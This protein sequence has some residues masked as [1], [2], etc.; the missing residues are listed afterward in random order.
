M[1]GSRLG[2]IQRSDEV[3]G[4]RVLVEKLPQGIAVHKNGILVYVNPAFARI[5]GCTPAEVTGRHWGDF[6]HPGDLAQAT[7]NAEQAVRFAGEGPM[8]P[9]ERRLLDKQGNVVAV[10]LVAVPLVFSHGPSLLI[11]VHDLTDRK[12]LEAQLRQADHMAAVGRLAAGVA[13]EINNPLA[14]VLANL[15]YA[16]ERLHAEG[17]DPAKRPDPSIQEAVT[18]AHQGVER[19]RQVVSDL[20][21]FTR[22]DEGELDL[23]DL[24]TVVESTIKMAYAEIRHSARLAR[25]YAPAP[26]VKAN[27]TKLAQVFLNLLVNAAQAIPEGRVAENAIMVG[28]GTDP[29]GHAVVEVRDTGVG[30]PDALLS[31]VTEP[32]FTTKP[33]GVGTGLGLS[34]CRNIVE[35]YMGRLSIESVVGW[36]TNVRVTLPPAPPGFAPRVSSMQV[37]AVRPRRYRVLIVDDDPMVLRSFR[38][39]LQRHD[40]TVATSGREALEI[41]ERSPLFEVILCDLMMPELTGMDVYE[42]LHERR[43]GYERR[44]IFLSGGV[45]TERARVFLDVVP[46]LRFEKPIDPDRLQA[47]LVSGV[48]ASIGIE[49]R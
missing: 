7:R 4:F 6:V 40:V 20:K 44:I 26:K 2:R 32:F 22:R 14:Y 46:N 29:E 39:V 11:V 42:R 10:E 5:L 27:Q 18:E 41:L 35:G 9:A 25:D 16:K 33:V 31:R 48:E 49:I 43:P 36:G 45:F 8:G 30:I 1:S 13:H 47:V 38:R 17:T 23:L 12:R 19:M 37:Q 34:V 21:T 15:S 28:I 24:A 3:D